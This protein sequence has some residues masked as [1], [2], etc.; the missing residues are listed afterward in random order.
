[1]DN[2]EATAE[3]P[4]F[5]A[6]EPLFHAVYQYRAHVS[7]FVMVGLYTLKSDAEAHEKY[8]KAADVKFCGAILSMTFA[9]LIR[10]LTD[11]R[12]GVIH[13]DLQ[14]LLE[15]TAAPDLFVVEYVE[16]NAL[17]GVTLVRKARA[18][19]SLHEACVAVVERA[20][21]AAEFAAHFQVL[22]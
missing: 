16:R 21:E 10:R 3:R 19:R 5:V 11:E 22:E 8:L 20:I 7:D 6:P 14:K 17:G 9:D 13:A 18:Q 4:E 15:R 2:S 1:V 12:L